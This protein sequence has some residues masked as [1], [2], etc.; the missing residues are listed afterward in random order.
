MALH[1][2][3]LRKVRRQRVRTQ[4]AQR[5][6]GFKK[7][8]AYLMGQLGANRAAFKEQ[9]L[10]RLVN[11]QQFPRGQSIFAP[12]YTRMRVDAGDNSI[13][14]VQHTFGGQFAEIL[15]KEMAMF[16]ACY[17]RPLDCVQGELYP[18]KK[19]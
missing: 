7:G 6:A 14:D 16:K 18:E 19:A 5:A 4:A 12:M 11:V 3:H 15:K 9:V 17:C 8:L 1:R 2:L 10:G 13:V